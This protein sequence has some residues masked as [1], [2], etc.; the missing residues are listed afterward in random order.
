MY[1]ESWL[2][3]II[4]DNT[5]PQYQDVSLAEETSADWVHEE[6]ITPKIA[7]GHV[8]IKLQYPESIWADAYSEHDNP[9]MLI[10]AI[11]VMCLRSN[12]AEV[13]ANIKQ[14]YSFKSPFPDDSN[15]SSL[16]F[17]EANI[18]AKAG[19]KIWWSEIVGLVMPRIS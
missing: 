14:A 2:I 3:G 8:G 18:V 4:K 12:Y 13:R 16:V 1:N 10:T 15:Y 9:E 6:L 17:L 19:T 11:Q 5:S 7:I